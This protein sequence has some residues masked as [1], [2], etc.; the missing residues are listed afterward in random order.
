M[1][2]R[3]STHGAARSLFYTNRDSAKGAQA[4]VGATRASR[5]DV[6][7]PWAHSVVHARW[8]RTHDRR[9]V[10]RVLD[11]TPAF[12]A[13]RGARQPPESSRSSRARRCWRDRCGGATFGGV[14]GHGAGAA[15]GALG[16]LS[17]RARPRRV[18]DRV[19]EAVRTIDVLWHAT[20]RHTLARDAAAT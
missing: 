17:D 6:W 11:D 10:G 18:V 16:R 12:V 9:R 5:G 3:A 2:C 20:A 1:L 15:T 8:H 14:E 13:A 19:A 4:L 7:D